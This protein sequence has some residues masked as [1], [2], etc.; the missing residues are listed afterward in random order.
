MPQHESDVLPVAE[1]SQPV[2]GEDALNCHDQIIPVWAY[3]L[4]EAFRIGLHVPLADDRTLL[5]Q[6]AE[7]HGLSVQIDSTVMLVSFGVE[8][9]MASVVSVMR[10]IYSLPKGRL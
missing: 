3:D 4:Q 1:I 10:A 5:I 6:N 9:H 7:V 8:F 2:P